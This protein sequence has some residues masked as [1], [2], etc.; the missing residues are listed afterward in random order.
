MES[1]QINETKGNEGIFLFENQI[2]TFDDKK[3]VT[4]LA[5]KYQGMIRCWPS[6]S[7]CGQMYWKLEEKF[8]GQVSINS[9]IIAAAD[10]G[11][12]DAPTMRSPG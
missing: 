1:G 3:V 4:G 7:C 12:L 11:T 6:V 8:A 5:A 10:W 9:I 2:M